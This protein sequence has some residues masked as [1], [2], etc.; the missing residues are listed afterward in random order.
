MISNVTYKSSR[1][2]TALGSTAALLSFHF[3]CD[4]SLTGITRRCS[5]QLLFFT[6]FRLPCRFALVFLDR[7]LA[8]CWNPAAFFFLF[9]PAVFERQFARGSMRRLSISIRRSRRL[10]CNLSTA[11]PR[12]ERRLTVPPSSRSFQSPLEP[13]S[14]ACCGDKR[15]W[16]WDLPVNRRQK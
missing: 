3:N 15:F 8:S 9:S 13:V 6:P 10:L 5:V 1:H 16:L 7:W 12:S 11:D 4:A 14:C 2:L